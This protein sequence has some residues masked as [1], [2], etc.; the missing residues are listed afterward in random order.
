MRVTTILMIALLAAASAA[1]Q[2]RPLPFDSG[3][4]LDKEGATVATFDGQQVLAVQTGYAHRRDVK[5]LDGTIDVDVQ[6]T[7]RRSFV[8]INFRIV[9]EGEHEEFY[10]RPHKSQ[11]PDA[12]Q[13]APSWQGASAWQLYH[14]PGGT[15]AIGF[16]PGEWTHVRVAPHCS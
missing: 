3:W 14:G 5:M 4:A 7:R 13:Y 10:L 12:V 9:A 6:V 8:Y 1:A 11:L 2:E 15:A 16:E